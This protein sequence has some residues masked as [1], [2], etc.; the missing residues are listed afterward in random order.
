MQNHSKLS[1]QT[2][3]NIFLNC[4]NSERNNKEN[5]EREILKKSDKDLTET[6]DK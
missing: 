3:I 5:M 4:N 2:K 1:R 6:L